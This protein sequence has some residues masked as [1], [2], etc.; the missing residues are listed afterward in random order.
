MDRP[1]Y[2]V[3]RG[4]AP[5]EAALVAPLIREAVDRGHR[6][7]GWAYDADQR[8]MLASA[9]AKAGPL[10]SDDALM[11]LIQHEEPVV[12]VLCSSLT[13]GSLLPRLW[14]YRGLVVSIEHSW[15]PWL[16]RMA[17]PMRRIDRML[18]AMPGDV[19]AAG[20]RRTG[21]PFTLSEVQLE[22]TLPAGWF[23]LPRI[24]EHP[25]AGHGF[26]FLYFGN[27]TDPRDLAWAGVIG[28]AVEIVAQRHPSLQWLY[29]GQF[30][31]D[32]PDFVERRAAWVDDETMAGWIGCA[33]LL[34]CH[35]G[36]GTISKAAT[37]GTPTLALCS[38]LVYQGATEFWA[39]L[40]IH[41]LQ[42]AGIVT[43]CSCP[44]PAAAVARRMLAL[45]ERGRTSPVSSDGPVVAVSEIERIVGS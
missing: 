25:L 38:D 15:Q 6:V 44:A 20:D 45:L 17:S 26:V 12:V 3:A 2:F 13:C 4:R 1:W 36:M 30:Q 23:G 29:R 41:A 19:W 7:V 35:H 14:E 43:G 5:G 37:T 10:P 32:L 8:R 16:P 39:E 22:R 33:D 18:L 40:E 21:G 24:P 9:G 27:G 42:R 11:V 34:V 28:S 31:L